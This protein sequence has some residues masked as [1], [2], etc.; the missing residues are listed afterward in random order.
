MS[1]NVVVRRAVSGDE[2]LWRRAVDALVPEADR[3]GRLASE[4]HIATALADPRC[5]LNL[6]LEDGEPVGILSGYRFPDVGAGGYLVYLYD[7]EVKADHRRRG[8]GSDLVDALVAACED[9]G[10]RMIWAGT[11]IEN[12]AARRT[13]ESTGGDLEGDSY[14]EY[15]WDL[16]D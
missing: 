8:I 11:D 13:F 4:D 5:Y 16:E 1:G 3:D 15:E 12:R 6:A 9:D 2:A 14:A 10:V 7:I